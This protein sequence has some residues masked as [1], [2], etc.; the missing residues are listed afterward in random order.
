MSREHDDIC[1]ALSALCKKAGVKTLVQ[2]GAEDGYEAWYVQ[3]DIGCRAIAIEADYKCEPCS[4]AIE[5]HRLMIGRSDKRAEFNVC[6]IA[7]LSSAVPRNHGYE[8]RLVH[9]QQ[10]RLDTFCKL[11]RIEPEAIIVDTE[12]TVIDVLVGAGDILNTLKLAYLEVAT[13]N[14]GDVDA[15][16]SKAGMRRH[17]STP[18]YES[19]D[20]ANVTWVRK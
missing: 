4:P 16:M 20:Q 9:R 11:Y 13:D 15:I 12:G 5:W 7:G 8:T 14:S 10:M 3:D 2:V 19:G 18:T 1:A 17:M 6:A